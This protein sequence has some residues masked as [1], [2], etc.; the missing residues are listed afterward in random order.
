M[1]FLYIRLLAAFTPLYLILKKVKQGQ[2]KTKT[3]FYYL[4]NLLSKTFNSKFMKVKLTILY[5]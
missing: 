1:L 5:L 4:G 2:D 3:S